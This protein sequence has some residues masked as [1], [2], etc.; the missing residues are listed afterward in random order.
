MKKQDLELWMKLSIWKPRH[1]TLKIEI[2][3]VMVFFFFV[4]FADNDA[5]MKLVA[6]IKEMKDFFHYFIK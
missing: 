3:A 5:S 1:R 6:Q 4:D 2:C